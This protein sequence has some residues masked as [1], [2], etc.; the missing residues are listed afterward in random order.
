MENDIKIEQANNGGFIV[1]ALTSQ[2]VVPVVHGA[3]TNGADLLRAM[4]ELLG[5][6]ALHVE[7]HRLRPDAAPR[8]PAIFTRAKRT[9]RDDLSI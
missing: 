5:L 9:Y 6:D 4:P 2:A 7:V 1:S 3:F 8:E